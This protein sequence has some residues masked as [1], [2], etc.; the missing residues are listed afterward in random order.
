MAWPAGNNAVFSMI[1]QT[2]LPSGVP[3]EDVF[4][5]GQVQQE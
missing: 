1:F 2:A 4:R 3:P 5:L